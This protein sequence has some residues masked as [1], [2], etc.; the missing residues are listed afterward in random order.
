MPSERAAGMS[1]LTL[2][3]AAAWKITISVFRFPVSGFHIEP[4]NF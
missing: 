1:I 2:K 3:V 4:R